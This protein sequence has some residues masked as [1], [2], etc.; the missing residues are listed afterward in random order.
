MGEL[1]LR[2][3]FSFEDEQIAVEAKRD[4]DQRRRRRRFVFFLDS[5]LALPEAVLTDFLELLHDLVSVCGISCTLLHVYDVVPPD[6]NVGLDNR[7]AWYGATDKI[8]LSS[9]L[10]LIS[11][12]RRRKLIDDMLHFVQTDFLVPLQ[13]SP[14]TI[15][16]WSVTIAEHQ[17]DPLLFYGFIDDVQLFDLIS[18]TLALLA[19]SKCKHRSNLSIGFGEMQEGR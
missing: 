16:D 5:R 1:E 19:T 9:V 8:E 10:Y 11:P 12:K 6:Y 18:L 14:D 17:H 15:R 2:E 4:H 3:D 13:I 7:A